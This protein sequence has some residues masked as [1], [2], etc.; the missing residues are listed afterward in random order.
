MY[1]SYT[2]P[3]LPCF[4]LKRKRSIVVHFIYITFMPQ[5]LPI[6]MLDSI[7]SPQ[8]V[9]GLRAANLPVLAAELRESMIA[10][11]AETGGHLGAGLG[12]VELT[13]ALHYVFN[14]PTDRLIWDVGHQA[15]PH[16]MLTN[17]RVKMHT[18][19]QKGGLSGFT[20]RSESPF[21][22]FGAGHSSTSLSAG[23]GMAAGR[24]LQ[25][26]GS[27]TNSHVISIIG[28]G[29]MSAGMAYEAMNH[30][31]SLDTRLI[32]ILNDNQMSI[33]PAVG[34]MHGY[35]SRL[36]SSGL[37]EGIRNRLKPLVE[38]LPKPLGAILKQG[39][40]T[41]RSG[42][43]RGTLFEELGL[44]YIG[45]VD[46]HNFDQLLPVLEN[47]RDM[48]AKD[49]QGGAILVHVVTK[50]G[51]GYAPS[52]AAADKLH[53][54]GKFDLAKGPAI[55]TAAITAPLSCRSMF[56]VA[57]DR[58]HLKTLKCSDLFASA[59]SVLAEQD[60]SIVAITAA[61]PDGTGLSDFAKQFKDRFFDVG[62]AEQHAVT[63]A[64]GLASDTDSKANI[65]P[66]VA[67]YSTFLQR[68]YDQIVH[69]VA[70]QNLPVRFVIDRAGLVGND[71]AT[72][73]GS[74]D[75]AYLGCLPN[76]VLMAAGTGADLVQMVATMAA[77]NTSPIAVRF[78]RG[79]LPWDVVSPE[80][81]NLL[82]P[83]PIGKGRIV[84][85]GNGQFALLS[86]GDRLEACMAAANNFGDGVITVADG[87]FTKPLDTD[88]I[89]ELCKN[90]KWVVT[91]ESGSRG[92][93]GSIVLEYATNSGLMDNTGVKLRTLCLPDTFQDHATQEQQY[94]EAGLDAAGIAEY[95]RRI[96]L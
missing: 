81:P 84:R 22:P 38:G 75:T 9:R 43:G 6:S 19:R 35:L 10:S 17:R 21:D 72:H 13:I 1:Y 50:K 61:M 69:D 11:V 90:H 31:G 65:K 87:R 37:Y 66:F 71:G 24:D 44:H 62:I 7:H 67:I 93:F 42:F 54:V 70:V 27:E 86:Y 41:V 47:V 83:L 94:A 8:D 36:T 34:A 95:V 73:A 28:D 68:A 63:F 3:R 53:A 64:A 32:I 58:E 4:N 89:T 20:K 33:A 85:Q 25:D 92:G 45:P 18:L 88:L 96:G 76:M 82:T 12:V 26:N 39:E 77:H 30:A 5:P 46:G 49:P 55:S 57:A 79:N 91:V 56:E 16:K 80:P 2:A 52:D 59:L 23:L 74:F 60:K 51:H 40:H 15:Y 78:P 48:A 29:A 14:T